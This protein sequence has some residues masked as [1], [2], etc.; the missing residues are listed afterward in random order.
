[1][2]HEQ[3]DHQAHEDEGLSS[4]I[5]LGHFKCSKNET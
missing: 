5:E 3:R 4:K 2:A 1:M